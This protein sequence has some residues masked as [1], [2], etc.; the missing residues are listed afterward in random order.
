MLEKAKNN[1][2]FSNFTPKTKA[3]FSK[4]GPKVWCFDFKEI[5]LAQRTITIFKV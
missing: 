3:N 1:V 5:I 2:L 4:D